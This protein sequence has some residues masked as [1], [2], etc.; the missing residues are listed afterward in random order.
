MFI[1]V[2]LGNLGKRNKHWEEFVS[3]PC[4]YKIIKEAAEYKKENQY[5]VNSGNQVKS[6]EYVL[7][8][9]KFH[10][11]VKSCIEKNCCVWNKMKMHKAKRCKR[12]GVKHHKY[13]DYHFLWIWKGN[14][15]SQNVNVNPCKG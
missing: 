15:L 6:A 1:K 11:Q 12:D 2:F 8:Y 4:E 7:K 3:E 5:H 9:E 10:N 13:P 14:I